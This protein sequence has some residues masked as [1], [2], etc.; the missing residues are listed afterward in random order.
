L[1][2]IN[3]KLISKEQLNYPVQDMLIKDDY[4]ILGLLIVNNP[5]QTL[6]ASSNMIP[7]EKMAS[8]GTPSSVKYLNS[9]IVFKEIFE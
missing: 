7:N 4:C 8:E 5:K 2:S 6:N 9:K 1:Y 3:G